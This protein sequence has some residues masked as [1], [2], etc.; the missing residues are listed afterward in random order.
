MKIVPTRRTDYAI[1][2]LIYLAGRPGDRV[3][4][5]E[6][7]GEMEIPTPIL[8]QVLGE[9]QRAGLVSSQSGPTGGYRLARDPES[10]PL[11]EVV[12]ALEGSVHLDECAFRGGPCHWEDV[13]A[14]HAVWTEAR[15]AFASSLAGHTLSE[16]A[17][18][19]RR[20]RRGM[21][22]IPAD[23]HRQ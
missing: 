13:C 22:E 18:V 1:R 3:N 17:E 7:A 2:A 10:V 20:L 16:V 21:A 8:H 11:L 6:I 23:S 9:L 5:A 4:A 19:D 15:E 14:I 12:E